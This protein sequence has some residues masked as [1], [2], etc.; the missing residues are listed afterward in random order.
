MKAQVIIAAGGIGSRMKADVPKPLLWLGGKPVIV[1]TLRVFDAHPLVKGV[2]LVVH[3]DYIQEYRRV[4]EAA[5]FKKEFCIMPGGKT[6]TQSV[7]I[8]LLALDQDTDTVIVHDAARPFVTG[9]MISE[10]LRITSDMHAAAAGV[11][12]KSTLKRVDPLTG[13]VQET[14][15]R[16]IVWEIQTPQMF[17]RELLERAHTD[18]CDAT[19]DAALVERMGN[20]VKIY[21]GDYRNIKITTPED[22][23]IAE[24]F[25]KRSL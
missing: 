19:D 16:S 10:G 17:K 12:V 18:K 14:L 9:E 13:L 4:I 7:R 23:D 24:V 5:G 20:R 11:P 21:M 15:E 25:L 2:V 8:G 22:M 1:H 6:R 3:K